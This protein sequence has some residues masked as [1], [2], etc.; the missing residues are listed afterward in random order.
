VANIFTKWPALFV[1]FGGGV[2]CFGK[3]SCSQYVAAHD[4]GLLI[5]LPLSHTHTVLDYK[6]WSPQ[7]VYMALGTK[8]RALNTPAKHPELQA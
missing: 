6:N 7:P 4:L 8:P 3:F 5:L 2:L 1:G